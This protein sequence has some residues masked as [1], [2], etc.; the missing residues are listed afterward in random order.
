MLKKIIDRIDEIQVKSSGTISIIAI[1]GGGGSGKSTL[2]ACIA[3]ELKGV[4]IVHMD[5][6]YKLRE[7]RKIK[8]LS[9]APSGYEYDIDRL[10]SEVILPLCDGK[11]ARFQIN[12]WGREGLTDFKEV[13]PSGVLLI[14]G[15]YSM[16]DRLR[17]F[18]QLQIFVDCGRSLR[19][20]R[21]LERDGDAAL[22]FWTNW[23][24]G[25]DQ[26]F[27]EQQPKGAADFVYSGES[28]V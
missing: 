27:A 18:Y 26:Y 10:I 9:E 8:D 15:C 20:K 23:M 19:L 2:A 1:E 12:G 7:F 13:T 17:G 14:E 6:F 16:L 22:Q 4:Q 11:T 5:D 3:S 28:S 21:G 25:E 24:A